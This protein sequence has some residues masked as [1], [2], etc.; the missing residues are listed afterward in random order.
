MKLSTSQTES[1]VRKI[2]SGLE[3][4]NLIS[5]SKGKEAALA[6]ARD[7]I[8]EDFKKEASLDAEVEKMMDRMEVENGPFQR[9]KMFGK[10]KQ[11]IAE[12]KG[13]VL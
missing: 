2:I 1:L 5:L 7:I 6:K 3:K 12:E 11:K 9:H 8:L 10:L 4:K 13:V